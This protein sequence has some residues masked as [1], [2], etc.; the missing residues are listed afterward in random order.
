MQ[1]ILRY[2][3]F[4]FVYIYDKYSSDLTVAAD[5]PVPQPTTSNDDVYDSDNDSAADDQEWHESIE[6]AEIVRNYLTT[7]GICISAR[8]RH[9]D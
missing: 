7:V 4:N 9:F 8:F 3:A 1:I 2:F 6:R 5:L